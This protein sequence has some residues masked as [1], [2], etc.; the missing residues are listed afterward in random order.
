MEFFSGNY[1]SALGVLRREIFT[2]ARESPRDFSVDAPRG[3]GDKLGT[4][5]TMPAPKNL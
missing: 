1:I 5:F 3:R 2:R 4:I